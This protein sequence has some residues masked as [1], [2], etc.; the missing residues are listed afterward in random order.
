M[1]Q[2]SPVP[3]WFGKAEADQ[4]QTHAAKTRGLGCGL[5]V[6]LGLVAVGSLYWAVTAQLRVN[7]LEERLRSQQ[8]DEAE[9]RVGEGRAR[10]AGTQGRPALPVPVPAPAIAVPAPAAAAT[11]VPA[12]ATDD[13]PP[14]GQRSAADIQKEM[15][16]LRSAFRRCYDV[17]L[18]D[19]PAAAGRISL[20]LV[21]GPRGDVTSATTSATGDLPPSVGSCVVKVART[22]SFGPADGPTN[23]TY[24]LTFQP[25]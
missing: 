19:N 15:S 5:G 8:A 22:A 23:V 10:A 20:K 18:N 17:V 14:V 24:P 11:A 12:P 25:G 1:T 13:A 2:N 9:R 7:H 6:L 4:R 21:I 16:R 3:D